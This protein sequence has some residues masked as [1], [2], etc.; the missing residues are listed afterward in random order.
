MEQRVKELEFLQNTLG[1]EVVE[2][3][4]LLHEKG[5]LPLYL[6]QMPD[7]EIFIDGKRVILEFKSDLK[8]S[9]PEQLENQKKV[10]EQN[11]NAVVV[12]C[13][14]ILEPYERKRLIERRIGFIVTDKQVYIPS[15]MMNLNEFT[16]GQKVKRDTASPAT[17]FLLLY[18]LQVKELGGIPLGKISLGKIP[19]PLEHYAQMSISRAAKEL[20][21]KG[22]CAIEGGRTKTLKFGLSKR[23]LWSKALPFL[24]SPIKKILYTM[25]SP[26]MDGM[27]QSGDKALAYYSSLNEGTTPCIAMG[28]RSFKQS[29]HQYQFFPT[30]F[31]GS[32]RFEVWKYEPALL[33]KN[34]M[35]DP[36]SLY[37]C[38]K[39]D[40]DERVQIALNEVLEHVK[41]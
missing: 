23:E 35:A 22:L 37:L 12:F 28:E 31:G 38:Y 11:Y 39:D 36:L 18:H 8:N 32:C 30:Q 34:N 26:L 2:G 41:W 15:L 29:E 33:S 40:N 20:E 3:K 24:S 21:S 9:T 5:S 25:Y 1:L 16:A 19:N 14:E 4:S 17:Q 13:F 27:T 6:R 7:K 10:L